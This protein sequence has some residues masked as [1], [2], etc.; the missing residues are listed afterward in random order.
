MAMG[1][2]S[3]NKLKDGE[4]ISKVNDNHF[5]WAEDDGDTLSDLGDDWAI[6]NG[7]F[8]TTREN[9]ILKE[10]DGQRIPISNSEV[11]VPDTLAPTSLVHPDTA[12]NNN[13][14]L[15]NEVATNLGITKDNNPMIQMPTSDDIPT[16]PLPSTSLHAAGGINKGL[17]PSPSADN[18]TLN[19]VE[20]E[21]S[22][23][24]KTHVYN[25][26]DTY[27][28]TTTEITINVH[29]MDAERT[30][31]TTAPRKRAFDSTID[32]ANAPEVERTSNAPNRFRKN[33]Y[34]SH[35]RVTSP[36]RRIPRD[37]SRPKSEFG[38]PERN[39]HNSVF[40]DPS[41]SR[42]HSTPKAMTSRIHATRPVITQNALSIISKTLGANDVSSARA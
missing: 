6:P 2:A 41:H 13:Q 42:A 27:P 14:D 3:T 4:T 40:H 5:D 28:P 7:K 25:N 21:P 24:I 11:T 34:K 12:T 31:E 33:L 22:L 23:P 32:W 35:S 16:L 17:S 15:V 9:H 10:E 19:P 1:N 8:D 38:S 20:V 26:E 18:L 30:G 39:H 29:N 37:P 36:I